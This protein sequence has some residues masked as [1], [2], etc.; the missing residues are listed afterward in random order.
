MNRWRTLPKRGNTAEENEDAIALSD[1]V[2]AIADGATEAFFS[3]MWAQQLVEHLACNAAAWWEDPDATFAAR[4]AAAE[5]QWQTLLPLYESLPWHAQ[6]KAFYG[7]AAA[8]AVVVFTADRWRG[9]AVGDV[10]IFHLRGATLVQSWPM[11]TPEAFTTRPPL[12]G[13]RACAPIAL[14]DSLWE[15]GD[16]PLVMTDALAAWALRCARAERPLWADLRALVDTDDQETDR[17]AWEAFVQQARSAGMKN[18]DVLIV[19]VPYPGG[20]DE[21]THGLPSGD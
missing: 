3:R 9:I 1:G 11:T 19:R 18:D 20:D 13:T 14:R 8:I 2:L 6:N 15:P 12:V 5:T 21:V 10:T 17:D 4:V 16:D 7:S